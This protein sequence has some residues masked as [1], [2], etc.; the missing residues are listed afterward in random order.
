MAC[1]QAIIT[2]VSEKNPNKRCAEI[3]ATHSILFLFCTVAV[4]ISALYTSAKKGSYKKVITVSNNRFLKVLLE[5]KQLLPCWLYPR[6]DK[7]A[8]RYREILRSSIKRTFTDSGTFPWPEKRS[9]TE[10]T[11]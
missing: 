1:V 9:S 8:L 2:R 3:A 10:E 4:T 11:Q 7:E 6:D 5:V